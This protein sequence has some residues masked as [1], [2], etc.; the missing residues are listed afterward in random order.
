MFNKNLLYS[1]D[2]SR[3]DISLLYDPGDGDLFHKEPLR[4]VDSINVEMYHFTDFEHVPPEVLLL[5]RL[6]SEVLQAQ[7]AEVRVVDEAVL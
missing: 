5:L 7:L 1:D 4:D 2:V 6:L 3:H